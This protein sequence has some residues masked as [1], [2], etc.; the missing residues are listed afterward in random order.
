MFYFG[1]ACMSTNRYSQAAKLF[2]KLSKA[3]D[4]LFKEQVT[5]YLSLAYLGEAKNTTNKKDREKLINKSKDQ[6]KKIAE[7]KM[8]D[9]NAANVESAI[10]MI[11]GTARSMGIVVE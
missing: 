11:A 10:R 4:N 1:N 3:P 2:S 9:L 7:M 8:E 6:L 5:W